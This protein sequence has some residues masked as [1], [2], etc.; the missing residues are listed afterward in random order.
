MENTGIEWTTHSFNPWHGCMKVSPGCANCYAEAQDKRFG[1]SHWGPGSDRKMMSYK[2]WQEPL[3]WEKQASETGQ[4]IRVFCAS[5]ADIFEDHP[6]TGPAL[7]MLFELIRDT[8]RL[9]WQLL[10]KRPQNIMRL[11]PQGWRE[12]FPM[13]VWIG[14]SVEDQERAAERI[15]H[16]LRVPAAIRFLSCEPLLGSLELEEINFVGWHE[17]AGCK[18][19]ALSGKGSMYLFPTDGFAK[20]NWIIAGGE[21]GPR[22]R[23]MG[24]DWLRGLRDQCVKNNTAFF[25][26]QWGEWGYL[27]EDNSGPFLGS[28]AHKM[29][30]K[31]TGSL[32]DGVSYKQFPDV[33]GFL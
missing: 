13:N 32:L 22:A 4:T 30:K 26:K 7:N 2:Y 31:A 8:P 1:P 33:A 20:I 21:S 29:G 28:I 3:K 23:P 14:T 10:T 5:M 11:V 6:T 24:I 25:F 17:E 27:P 12:V 15:P 18:L 16:L 19:N 9:T